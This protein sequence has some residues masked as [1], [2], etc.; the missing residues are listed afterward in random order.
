MFR[1]IVNDEVTLILS[2]DVNN[3]VIAGKEAEC[4]RLFDAL[5]GENSHE[6]A[7]GIDLV[8]RVCFQSG[9]E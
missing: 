3:M 7:R 8:H 5:L 6:E 1:D 9:L 4:N 2:V